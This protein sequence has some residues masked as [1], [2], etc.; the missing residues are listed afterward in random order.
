MAGHVEGQT[1]DRV[2]IICLL[3]FRKSLTD[4]ALTVRVI[5]PLTF[6]KDD[7]KLVHQEKL[8][9][10]KDGEKRLRLGNL[11][12]TKPGAPFACHSIWGETIGTKDLDAGQHAIY[13]S[14]NLIEIAVGV[15]TY[16][17][18]AHVLDTQRKEQAYVYLLP[19]SDLPDFK[20]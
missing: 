8:T 12:I 9:I 6:K 4:E 2:D 5:V 19:E 1:N 10:A 14:K 13:A 7:K 17:I 3:K 18:Y 15:Q 20:N 11:A 16:R